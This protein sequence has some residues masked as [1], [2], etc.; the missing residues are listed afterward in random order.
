M[1]EKH[2]AHERVAV[3]VEA[4]GREAEQPVAG[5]DRAPV[6]PA[7]LL[8]HADR[9]A[10]EV[11]LA[12]GVEPGQLR[13]LAADEGAAGGLAAVGD[14]GDHP[15]GHADVQLARGEVVEEEQR[16]GAAHDEVVDVHGD[17]VDADRVVPAR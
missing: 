12:V 10:G 7:A 2:P 13:G 8:D 16:L 17:Q 1:V 4:R 3:R 15:L 6:D 5:R 14:A 11:V 9:E